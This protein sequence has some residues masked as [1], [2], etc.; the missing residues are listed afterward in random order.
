[1]RQLLHHCQ[2][3]LEAG[4][5][6][7]QHP[8]Q[9]TA[10]QR[11]TFCPSW[12]LRTHPAA[13]LSQIGVLGCWMVEIETVDVIT[14]AS[15]L[16]LQLARPKDGHL[17]AICHI[18][19]CLDDEHNS[20]VVSDPTHAEMEMS[21]FSAER[22]WREFCGNISKPALANGPEPHVTRTSEDVEICL[23]VDSDHAGDQLVR[24][25]LR[26]GFLVFLNSAPLIWFAKQQPT[27]GDFSV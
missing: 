7:H 10:D 23:C 14:E 4:E 15:M 11:S 18:F 16:E 17:E 26:A 21:V 12:A 2:W 6:K 5:E 13:H 8:S 22:D 9:K 25:H 27:V 3:F 20:C 19:A 1:M 24:Q